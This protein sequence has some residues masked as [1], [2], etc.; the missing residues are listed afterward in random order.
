MSTL[1][2]RLHVLIDEDGHLWAIDNGLSFH[3]EF[4]LR[5]VVWDFGGEPI[6]DDGLERFPESR[7]R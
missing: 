7:P 2:R 5:T 3:Q 6:P 1:E 4:K